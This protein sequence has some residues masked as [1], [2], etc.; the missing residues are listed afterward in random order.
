MKTIDLKDWT[1]FSARRNSDNYFDKDEKTMLKVFNIGDE[2]EIIESLEK[3][4]KIAKL[5]TDAGIKTPAVGDFGRTQD[6]RLCM[7]YENIKG[8]KSLSRA[9]S[10]DKSLA[11][12][13]MELFAEMG[14]QIHA[15]KCEE[16]W[17]PNYKELVRMHLPDIPDVSDE[18]K[19][20]ML[21]FVE[22]LPD[23]DSCLHGDFHPGNFIIADGTVYAIDLTDMAK[24][25]Y[26]YDIAWFYSITITGSTRAKN[27]ILHWDDELSKK[28]WGYFTK[29]YF[30]NNVPDEQELRIYAKVWKI[31][32]LPLVVH[33]TTM[34]PQN[35]DA[36]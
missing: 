16:D 22:K 1:L 18:K 31:A 35:D 8:K 24:G 13:Y 11:E 10:E 15:T 17:I 26:L 2:K 12:P 6:G 36:F 29:Y 19:A 30:G 20:D 21:A 28:C 34:S 25:Y 4:K 3:D 7:T 14:K 9:V 32:R 5:Y 33:T 27:E 23:G